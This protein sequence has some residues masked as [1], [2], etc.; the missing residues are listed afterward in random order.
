MG[1]VIIRSFTNENEF[2]KLKKEIQQELFERKIDGVYVSG[3]MEWSEGSPF[4]I[5]AE[6]QTGAIVSLA[7]AEQEIGKITGIAYRYINNGNKPK[8][9]RQ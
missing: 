9:L 5:R 8:N 7:E 4:V 1:I 6:N 2:D 3:K